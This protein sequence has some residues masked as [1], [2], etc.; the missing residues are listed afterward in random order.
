MAI[1]MPEVGD[2][3]T[4]YDLGRILEMIGKAFQE[5][6]HAMLVNAEDEVT[7]TVDQ[8]LQRVL[9]AVRTLRGYE[10]KI[11][12]LENDLI[13]RLDESYKKL[14]KARDRFAEQVKS[15]PPLPAPDKVSFYQ[16]GEIL[17]LLERAAAMPDKAWERV[18]RMFELIGADDA[19]KTKADPNCPTR[20]AG[21]EGYHPRFLDRNEPATL[22]GIIDEAV[23]RM[24]ELK[25]QNRWP[26]SPD[27]PPMQVLVVEDDPDRADLIDQLKKM[28]HEKHFPSRVVLPTKPEGGY[29]IQRLDHPQDH[30]RVTGDRTTCRW[31][32]K[33][34][35]TNDPHPPG[36]AHMPLTTKT[37]TDET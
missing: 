35:D 26:K 8:C 4:K 15:L 3:L 31:C 6:P 25:R 10:L 24:N 30:V 13:A 36:C 12:E 5:F 19:Q 33:E 2:K 16:V 27:L 28:V 18:I 22:D 9:S 1:L 32:R 20:I 37:E 14:K 17:K 23:H 34:W 29:T 21:H 11:D 7:S